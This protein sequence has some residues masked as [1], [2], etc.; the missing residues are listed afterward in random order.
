MDDSFHQRIECDPAMENITIEFGFQRVLC[1]QSATGNRNN[2]HG[3][4]LVEQASACDLGF[5]PGFTG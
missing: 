1:M 5:S 2:S 3:E 4:S